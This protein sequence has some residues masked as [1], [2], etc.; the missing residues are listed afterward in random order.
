[1][2]P[3]ELALRRE[4]GLDVPVED[5]GWDPFQPIR[6]AF[7]ATQGVVPAAVQGLMPEQYAAA[8][9]EVQKNLGVDESSPWY[10]KTEALPGAGD[11]AAQFIP[12]SVRESLPGRIA[13]PVLRLGGN[14]LGDPTTYTPAIL[15]KAAG[16]LA[17]GTRGAEVLSAAGQVAREIPLMAEV[18]VARGIPIAAEEV[19]RA[20]ETA[21]KVGI[22]EAARAIAETSPLRS[23]A[24]LAAEAIKEAEPWAMGTAAAVAYGPQV[25]ESAYGSAKETLAAAGQGDL[26]QA[27][28]SGANTILMAGLGWLMGRGLIDTVAGD[29]DDHAGH[30]RPGDHPE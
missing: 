8:Q 6:T 21:R 15:G 18:D 5:T 11:V 9:A 1:M 27:A 16:L 25:V 24:Y 17:K 19:A 2:D 13:G 12:E 10:E 4:L 29:A 3:Y 30:G 28:V 20:V 23:K 14:I 26:E 7:G 22:G